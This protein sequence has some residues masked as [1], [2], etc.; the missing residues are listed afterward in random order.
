[1]ELISLSSGSKGNSFYANINGVSFLIDVGLSMKKLNEKLF[2]SAGISLDDIDIIVITHRHYD[3]IQSLHTIVKSYPN[4]KVLSHKS[5][6]DEYLE[7]YKHYIK[8]DRKIIIDK[9]FEG[10]NVKVKA[11]EL[12]HD[13]SCFGYIFTDKSN[14]ETFCFFADNG[15]ISYKHYDDY[16]GFTYY[17]I[18]SNH[19]LTLEVNNPN[20]ELLTKRRSLS[21]KGHTHNYNAIELVSNIVTP[22]TKGVIFHHL[23]EDCNNEELARLTH[24]NYLRIWGKI[25]ETR[26]IKFVYARQNEVVILS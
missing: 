5:V 8:P 9:V 12:N 18:E 23:S 3:H 11:F 26:H 6:F 16:K 17:A 22:N 21:Y 7:H 20:R 1:M 24:E 10:K 25:L 13:V 15:G 4:I 2:I 14:G 19:D